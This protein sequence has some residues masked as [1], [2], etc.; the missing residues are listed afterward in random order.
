[1]QALVV[2]LDNAYEAFSVDSQMKISEFKNM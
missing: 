2:H 1:M